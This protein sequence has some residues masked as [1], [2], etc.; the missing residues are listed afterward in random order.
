MFLIF[1]SDFGADFRFTSRLFT[2]SETSERKI[3][4]QAAVAGAA[5]F[6]V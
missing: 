2:A 3:D 6:R 5:H 4:A 1:W